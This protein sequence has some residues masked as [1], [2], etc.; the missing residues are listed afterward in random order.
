MDSSR[1]SQVVGPDAGYRECV[2]NL[3]GKGA[4]VLLGAVSSNATLYQQTPPTWDSENKTFTFKVSSPHLDALGKQNKGF[5]SLQIPIEQAKCRWGDDAS[6]PRAQVEIISQDGK[7]SITTAVAMNQN[8]MLKFNIAG[9]GYSAP[10]I[11]IKMSKNAIT[12]A[13]PTTS[14]KT[15]ITCVKGKTTKKVTAINPKCP[16]GYTKK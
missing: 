13:Q 12:P 7:T 5:Y 2:E 16:S 1:L 3:Y 11:R 14:K 10:S 6:L 4:R 8:G 15:T 9:F